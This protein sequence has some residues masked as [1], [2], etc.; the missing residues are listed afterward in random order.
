MYTYMDALSRMYTKPSDLS[1]LTDCNFYY[2]NSIECKARG[3]STGTAEAMEE[4]KNRETAP[5]VDPRRYSCRMVITLKTTD[6]RYA[7]KL[8][9]GMWVG[10]CYWR[11]E[12]IV[13]E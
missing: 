11:G 8:N 6:E 5:R 1:Q 2:Y 9:F 10:S 7:E 4:L 3:S 13:C 12:E